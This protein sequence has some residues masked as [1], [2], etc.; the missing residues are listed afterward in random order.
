MDNLTDD[1]M[2]IHLESSKADL[3]ELRKDAMMALHSADEMVLA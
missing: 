1:M 2:A 3:K